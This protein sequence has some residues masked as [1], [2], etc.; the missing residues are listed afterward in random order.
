MGTIASDS[1]GFDLPTDRC[2]L[3]TYLNAAGY[4]AEARSACR[5][6]PVLRRFFHKGFPWPRLHGNPNL[7]K[8]GCL[9]PIQ[10]LVTAAL[11][12]QEVLKGQCLL[13]WRTEEGT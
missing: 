2:K 11:V 3:H 9:R 7:F 4:T 10:E 12:A 6:V 8:D 1:S 5:R 13:T